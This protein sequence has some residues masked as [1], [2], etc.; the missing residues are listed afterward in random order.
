[1]IA[2]IY[3][4]LVLG[5]YLA[6]VKNIIDLSLLTLVIAGVIPLYFWRKAEHQN[7]L[8]HILVLT[9]SELVMSVVYGWSFLGLCAPIHMLLAIVLATGAHEQEQ[10]NMASRDKYHNVQLE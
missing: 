3:C 2:A 6:H 4:L 10:T 5:S 7:H 9:G 1:M 8:V